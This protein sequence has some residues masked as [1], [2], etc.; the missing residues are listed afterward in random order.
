[1]PGPDEGA[2]RAAALPARAGVRT[3][4]QFLRALAVMAVVLNHLFPNRLTGGYLGV[5]IFFV[6]SGF[7]ITAHLLG[8]LEREGR[9]SLARFWARRAR[10][11]LP[12]SLTVLAVCAAA[13]VAWLPQTRWPQVMSEVL[14]SALYF[15]NWQLARSA[16]DYFTSA[17]TASP[18]T[19]F[20]S[21]SVEEQFYLVWPLLVLG[22]WWLALRR[23]GASGALRPRGLTPRRT[24]GTG[25]AILGVASLAFAV[26]SVE[27]HPDAAY[28]I[29]P[30]RVWEFAA[31]G[32]LAAL[33][34]AQGAVRPRWVAIPG[35]LLM[36]GSICLFGDD[37]GVPGLSTLLPVA[38]CALVIWAGTGSAGRPAPRALRGPVW[39]GDISYS[40]Y[41]WHWP[42]I[43]FAPIALQRPMTPGLG[44]AILLVTLL[45]AQLSTRFVEDPLRRARWL[46]ARPAAMTLSG[47]AISMAAVAG[48]AIYIPTTVE[49]DLQAVQAEM[50]ELVADGGPCVGAAATAS[51]CPDSHELA[52]AGSSLLTIVN[53]PY[54]PTWGTTCQVEPEDPD[55][56]PCEFGVPKQEAVQRLALVGDS[57]AG[58]WA[59]T[60]DTIARER[61][62][63]VEMQVKS[64]CLPTTGDVHASWGT[65]PMIASCRAWSHQVRTA[66]ADDPD[67]DVIVMSG[68]ARDYASA[69]PDGVVE[70][71][72]ELW[73][74][75][76]EAGKQVVVMADPPYLGRGPVPECLAEASTRPDPCAALAAVVRTP[77]PLVVAAA[78]QDGVTV[79]DLT[80][81]V[82]DHRRCHAVVGGMPVYGDQNHLLQYFA[83]TMAP[84]VAKR[85]ATVPGLDQPQ[86]R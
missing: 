59:S 39:L 37:S 60:L 68:I 11:L 57:H 78:G 84:L 53:S 56:S 80:D 65:E 52:V 86:G 29:T 27:A 1:M 34:A 76:V 22:T 82:C 54:T 70:Q 72:R 2:R 75:W 4:I 20:W 85:L 73:A 45:T 6:I 51:G 62:W 63:N 41:L 55:P 12:A 81:V 8:E 28:F 50:E 24:V 32:V 23:G 14:A 69:D 25:L 3:D 21:L 48:V 79:V 33:A 67:I 71:L 17:Q 30:G 43:V 15:E 10:R 83:R 38:G 13:T 66:L 44:L 31:G 35:W 5:D 47:A 74:G 40:V 61:G 9:I 18:V 64:S 36:V 16:Q 49:D 19:H 46:T 7:L 77:D 58:Q 42:L 26:W